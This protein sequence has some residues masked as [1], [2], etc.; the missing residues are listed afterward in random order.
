MRRRWREWD[1]RKNFV[2]AVIMGE[3]HEFGD[4]GDNVDGLCPDVLCDI[5]GGPDGR[6]RGDEAVLSMGDV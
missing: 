1:R 2:C 4:E 3:G 6:A 5:D